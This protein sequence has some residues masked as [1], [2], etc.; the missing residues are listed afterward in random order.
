MLNDID[1]TPVPVDTTKQILTLDIN[2]EI[3]HQTGLVFQ[4]QVFVNLVVA[5][6][7]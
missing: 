4:N 6:E 7:N 5:H 1:I 2:T 3:Q